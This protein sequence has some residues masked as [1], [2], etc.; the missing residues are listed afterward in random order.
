MQA[1]TAEVGMSKPCTQPGRGNVWLM[2]VPWLQVKARPLAAA[3]VSSGIPGGAEAAT[4]VGGASKRKPAS[5]KQGPGNPCHQIKASS[6][7][8][9]RSEQL[10][11]EPNQDQ[12]QQ[13]F[14]AN[15]AEDDNNYNN[16]CP[17]L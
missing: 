8:S 10:E 2:A 16:G 3:T 5:V 17:I 6:P 4:L 15:S 7:I 1:N 11:Q 9:R 14:Q 13:R 12:G